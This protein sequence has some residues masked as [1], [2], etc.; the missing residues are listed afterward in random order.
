MVKKDVP[1][2][3]EY[4]KSHKK[5]SVRHKVLIAVAALVV[6]CTT[7]AMIL[8]AITM[9]GK[10]NCGL[11]EHTHQQNC[12]TTERVL[13]CKLNEGELHLHSEECYSNNGELICTAVTT[14]EHTHTDSCYTNKMIMACQEPMHEHSSSCFDAVQQSTEETSPTQLSSEAVTEIM[15]EPTSTEI[16]KGDKLQADSHSDSFKVNDETTG[17]RDLAKY[18]EEKYR[19]DPDGDV[20][21]VSYVVRDSKNNIIPDTSLVSGENYKFTLTIKSP[22]G[23]EPNTYQYALPAEIYLPGE[24]HTGKVSG[25]KDEH[26]GDFSAKRKGTVVI[27]ITFD[28]IMNDYQ[29]FEGTIGFNIGIDNGGEKPLSA[30]VSK[31]GEFNEVD[32]MFDFEIS[33]VIPAHGGSGTFREWYLF[34]QSVVWGSTS[35]WGQDLRDAEIEITYNVTNENGEMVAKTATVPHIDDVKAEDDIA[36][37]C[38]HLGETERRLYLVN[39]CKC[40]S[41]LCADYKTS[42]KKCKGLSLKFGS[43]YSDSKYSGWCTCWNLMKNSTLSIRYK[44]DEAPAMLGGSIKLINDCA[45]SQYV[46]TV[47]LMGG[48]SKPLTFTTNVDIPKLISKDMPTTFGPENNYIGEYVINVNESMIDLSKVDDDKDGLPD[49]KI[50]ISDVMSNVA[51]VPGSMTIVAQ[52]KDGNEYILNEG[53]EEDRLA[54]SVESPTE[55]VTEETTAEGSTEPATEEPTKSVDF[56]VEYTPGSEVASEEYIASLKI[57]I[58]N[59]K[60]Y[61]YTIK[62]EGVA[63]STEEEGVEMDVATSNT[64]TVDIYSG[65]SAYAETNCYFEEGWSYIKRSL[66][67]EKTDIDNGSFLPGAVFGLYTDKNVEIARGTTLDNGTYLFKTN[68][69]QGIIF[70]ENR[71]YYVKELD[72]PD[73]YSIDASKHWFYFAT[74]VNNAFKVEHAGIMFCGLDEDGQS[75]SN[76]MPVTNEKGMSLPETGGCGT[77]VYT[78]AGLLLLCVAAYVLHRKFFCWKGV[79]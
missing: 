49:G 1:K 71:Q 78:V 59:P 44:N 47:S 8:P 65:P 53:T 22:K 67:L 54:G 42:T 57:T 55:Q 14:E 7:Y 37:L 45:G 24:E 9:E 68:V 62:Y 25:N 76:T 79:L 75:D 5:R 3:K 39:R 36:F 28:E 21:E 27:T 61:M 38:H 12:Y 34:D 52:D 20:G 31:T 19:N 35:L 69:R 11:T 23:I 41:F 32:G 74:E 10:I 43:T 15:Y 6:F 33:A 50:T 73:G 60:D 2:I 58:Y 63:I 18:L 17:A 46:N 72:A 77:V 56:V 13:V 30:S 26:V 4:V 40:N 64:A 16:S 66:L 29:D 48:V 70:K 51:Y